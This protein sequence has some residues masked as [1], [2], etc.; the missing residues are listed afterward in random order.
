[1]GRSFPDHTP[2]V[3]LEIRKQLGTQSKEKQAQKV[4]STQIITKLR[5]I[6]MA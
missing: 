4:F 5:R 1:M 6:K 2:K 3:G